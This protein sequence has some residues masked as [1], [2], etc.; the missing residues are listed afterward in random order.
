MESL[1]MGVLDF[2]GSLTL[3][4]WLLLFITLFQ[5]HALNLLTSISENTYNIRR[6][7][8]TNMDR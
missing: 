4:E 7:K 3:I 5:F 2:I 1:I 8:R 6:I